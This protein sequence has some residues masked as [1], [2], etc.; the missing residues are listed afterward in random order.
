MLART[1]SGVR[2]DQ[3]AQEEALRLILASNAASRRGST[4]KQRRVSKADSDRL[5]AELGFVPAR[6]DDSSLAELL[7]F[8]PR[9]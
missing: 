6:L 7:G 5:R 9:H 8:A 3:K 4:A 2:V 1:G